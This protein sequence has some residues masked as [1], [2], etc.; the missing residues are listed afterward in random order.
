VLIVED[1]KDIRMLLAFMF[2]GEKFRVFQATDGQS[3][4]DLFTAEM[5][6]IDLLVTDLGLP[7]LGGVE[8]IQKVRAAKPS[9]RI[10]GSSGFGKK[11]IHEEV[12]NA[13]GDLFI[14]KPYVAT[15]LIRAAKQLLQWADE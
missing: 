10:I 8:L 12:L 6:R 3:A 11:N 4:M 14:S 7:K 1:E 5:E 15:E 13:G 9:I 2:E